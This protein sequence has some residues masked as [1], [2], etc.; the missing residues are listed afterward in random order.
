M[1]ARSLVQLSHDGGRSVGRYRTEYRRGMPGWEPLDYFGRS[2]VLWILEN[3]DALLAREGGEDTSDCIRRQGV[4][5]L[6][7]VGNVLT[8]DGCSQS[9]RISNGLPGAGR[10]H[11]KL[12]LVATEDCRV[13]AVATP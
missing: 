11:V 12:L 6:D 9:G 13:E 5:D 7:R 3:L 1:R 2:R 10:V 8:S 4:Q